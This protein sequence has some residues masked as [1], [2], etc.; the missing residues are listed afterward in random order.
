MKHKNPVTKFLASALVALL[1]CPPGLVLAQ[2]ANEL[3]AAALE[4][5]KPFD[6]GQFSAQGVQGVPAT[7]FSFVV[8]SSAKEVLSRRIGTVEENKIANDFLLAL[9]DEVQA[10]AAPTQPQACIKEDV[11]DDGKAGMGWVVGIIIPPLGLIMLI[12]ALIRDS[13]ES[14]KYNSCQADYPKNLAKF[15]QELFQ[16]RRYELQKQGDA[17][18]LHLDWKYQVTVGELRAAGYAVEVLD[19]G[20]FRITGNGRTATG[21]HEIAVIVAQIKLDE[22]LRRT[23]QRISDDGINFLV[24]P[25]PKPSRLW[26][27]KSLEAPAAT[28]GE[29]RAAGY[30][31]E[32]DNEGNYRLGDAYRWDKVEAILKTVANGRLQERLKR[33]AAEGKNF[34]VSYCPLEG[35]D[36]KTVETACELRATVAAIEAAGFEVSATSAGKLR[37]KNLEHR[38]YHYDSAYASAEQALQKTTGKKAD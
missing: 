30:E 9:A 29:L 26:E 31:L 23:R 2:S 36:G 35:R 10:P 32:L 18:T 25:S 28:I 16:W 11:W 22:L 5:G 4:A 38:Y 21:A 19:D 14:A 37:F 1:V 15:K 24:F 3:E 34:V 8:G 17:F 33:Y 20:E 27:T 12:M 6:H 7:D 13:Y